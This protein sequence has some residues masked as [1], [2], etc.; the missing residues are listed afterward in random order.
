[1]GIPMARI[2]FVDEMMAKGFNLMEP[3]A[4]LPEKPQL[5]L[6]FH[7]S[8]E[9]VKEQAELFGEIVAD[10][11][12]GHFKWTTKAEERTALWKLRHNARNSLRRT[13]DWTWQNEIH[14]CGTRGRFNAHGRYQTQL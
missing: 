3:E 13:R 5:F 2:E 1:M 9:S 14:G 7:G 6:E 4:N 12:G 11:G 10:M 8:E